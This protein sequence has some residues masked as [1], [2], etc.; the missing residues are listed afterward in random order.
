M[1]T[2]CRKNRQ[3]SLIPQDDCTT[4][5]QILMIFLLLMYYKV[6]QPVTYAEADKTNGFA[7]ITRSQTR[8]IACSGGGIYLAKKKLANLSI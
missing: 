7:A 3:K 4:A 2:Y 5:T 8:T 6:H 1:T